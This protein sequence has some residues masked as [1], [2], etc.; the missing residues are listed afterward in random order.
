MSKVKESTKT[1]QTA[2]KKIT[3]PWRSDT[4]RDTTYCYATAIKI[5]LL[6]GKYKRNHNEFNEICLFNA[7]VNDNA[8]FECSRAPTTL[9]FREKKKTFLK[10]K[11]TQNIP[12]F[13][14]SNIFFFKCFLP[15]LCCAIEITIKFAGKLEEA[16]N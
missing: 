13:V 10:K 14:V 4:R 5:N 7:F 15:I 12:Y 8:S 2:A 3:P 6:N 9:S 11:I 1:E 16:L